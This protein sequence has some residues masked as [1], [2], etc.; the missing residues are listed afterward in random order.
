MHTRIAGITVLA[1]VIL[2][3]ALAGDGSVDQFET[4]AISLG[5]LDAFGGTIAIGLDD[6]KRII[7][8]R[9]PRS[10]ALIN[11]LDMLI[12]GVVREAGT[13]LVTRDRDFSQ[14]GRT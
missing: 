2:K 6:A 11:P 5:D 3:A 1:K 8:G 10:G 9:I 7:S 12:A 13:V 14:R 4:L